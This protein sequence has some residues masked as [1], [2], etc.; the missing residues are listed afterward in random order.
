MQKRRF[1]ALIAGLAASAA[2][3]FSLP[4]TAQQYKDEYKLSTVLGEAFPWGGVTA[5]IVARATE[6]GFHLLDAP[7]MRLNSRDT[8]VPYHPKLWAAHRPT[9][10]SICQA[11]RKLLAF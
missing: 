9:P 1:T 7:P 11:L 2:L 6:E 10:E 4:A 5:E 8:P 3:G